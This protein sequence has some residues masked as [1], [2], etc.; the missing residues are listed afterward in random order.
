MA[1]A[2]GRKRPQTGGQGNGWQR[3]PW[4]AEI[5]RRAA[6]YDAEGDTREGRLVAADYLGMAALM[7]AL[8]VGFWMWAV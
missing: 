2:T 6:I 5:E 4:L 8:T 1:A 7:L 3:G